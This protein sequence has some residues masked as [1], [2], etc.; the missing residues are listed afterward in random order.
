MSVKK[1]GL[2]GKKLAHSFSKT[3]FTKKFK[4]LDIEATYDNIEIPAIRMVKTVLK[5]GAIYD[6]LNVTIPY[7]TAII[8]YLDEL[9][10]SAKAVGAVNTVLNKN[11]Q[12]IGFNTDVYGFKQM[13][14]PFFKSHHERALIFGTGGASKAVAFVLE[15]L[16][17]S[18]I[19]V[20]RTPEGANQFGYD[21]VNE[22][23]IA[24]NTIIVNCTPV[25]TY[26]N[27]DECLP[28]PYEALT[29]KHLVIDLIYNPEE[30]L[31]LK[32]A[33]AQQ[34]WTLNGLTML[35]QQA[36][37]AWEIWNK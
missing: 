1:F 4:E 18:V 21:E 36:E 25:G 24:F 33:K 13:I 30:T 8:P 26:P 14:K 28:L 5:H 12:F 3:Y 22:N 6:G 17:S 27:V 7:K 19:T 11:G 16:G 10:E 29:D 15:Q 20:S 31:F 9:D 23:M 34:A 37:K 32:K 2:I 35:H